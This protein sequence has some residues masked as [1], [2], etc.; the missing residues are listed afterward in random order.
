M[1]RYDDYFCV[2]KPVAVECRPDYVL[3]V[4]FANGERGLFD[5]KPYLDKGGVFK[6]LRDADAFRG[7]R[8]VGGTVAWKGEHCLIDLAP[9]TVYHASAKTAAD[10]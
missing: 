8:I 5:M 2:P 6:Q 1:K 10:Q 4:E 7:A 9:E 3:A